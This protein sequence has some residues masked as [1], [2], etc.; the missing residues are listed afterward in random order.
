MRNGSGLIAAVVSVCGLAGSVVLAAPPEPG[1]VYDDAPWAVQSCVVDVPLGSGDVLQRSIPR[2]GPGD[3]L[4][5]VVF[6]GDGYTASE[7]AEFLADANAAADDIFAYEPFISYLPFIDF[8][9]IE[10]VSNDSGVTNDPVEGIQRD[11]AL[12]MRYFCN[13]IERLLC[14]NTSTARGIAGFNVP[15]WDVI[16][17]LANS[18]KYGGAGYP[19][20]DVATAAAKNSAAGDIVIHEIGHALGDLADEYTYGGPTQWPGGEPSTENVSI[21]NSTQMAA[22]NRKWAEWLGASLPGFDNPMTTVEGGNYSV[23]GIYRPTNNSMMRALG[24]PFNL[25][26]AQELIISFHDASDMIRSATP[27]PGQVDASGSLT[28]DVLE[29]ALGPMF[30]RWVV[31][32]EVVS[33]GSGLYSIDVSS[34][35]AVSGDEVRVEVVDDTPWVRNEQAREQVMT[36]RVS[37]EVVSSACNVADQAAPL[38]VL[39]L[40]DV[41]RF[42]IAYVTGFADADIAAP[43]GTVDLSDIDAFIAAFLAGCP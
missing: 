16:V 22:Q 42:V 40:S 33:Q 24:R 35:G 13:G 38:G 30:V 41:D 39:D 17:P 8:H 29:T 18:S 4:V 15:G 2:N 19:S 20:V 23:Q 1:V 10:V 14:V 31:N 21:F 25:V 32:G 7:Q 34:L 5:D 27:A 26:S 43:F 36:E 11:T 9:F 28:V 6:M 37:W 3:E 12:E